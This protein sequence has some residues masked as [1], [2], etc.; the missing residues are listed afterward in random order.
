MGR[1]KQYDREE[2]LQRAVEV[3]WRRGYTA[4]STA[5]LVEELGVNRKTMYSEFGS[6]Q[7]LF[8]AALDHYSQT[9]LGQWFEPIE[10]ADASLAGIK[11]IFRNF[12]DASEGPAKGLGCLLCNTAAERA[13]IDA[14]TEPCVDAYLQRIENAF[15]H[16]LENARKKKELREPV[17]SAELASFLTTCLIGAVTS[18]R[19]EAPPAQLRATHEMICLLLDNYSRTDGSPS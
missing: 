13:V 7:A 15:L 14:T 12:A 5:E 16:A 17:Q 11:Q 8:E 4:T 2:L 1:D 6:K 10:T 3:F 9:I 18:I 19:A